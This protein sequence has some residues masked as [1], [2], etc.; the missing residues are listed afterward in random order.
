V[1]IIL[2]IYR[3]QIRQ[4]TTVAAALQ[5][6]R[7]ETITTT[8]FRKTT[9]DLHLVTTREPVRPGTCAGRKRSCSRFLSRW[10]ARRP[11]HLPRGEEHRHG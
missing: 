1:G 5:F 2:L 8:W 6:V 3:G 11:C 7:R 4:F 10:T 9:G